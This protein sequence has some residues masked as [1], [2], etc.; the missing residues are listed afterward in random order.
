MSMK[1]PPRQ[2]N[3]AAS[4]PGGPSPLKNELFFYFYNLPKQSGVNTPQFQDAWNR[5]LTMDLTPKN[6]SLIMHRTAAAFKTIRHSPQGKSLRLAVDQG[7]ERW[8]RCALSQIGQFN[9]QNLTNSLWAFATLGVRPSSDFLH[10]WQA[11]AAMEMGAFTSQNLANSLWAFAT[12]GVQPSNDV[13]RQWQTRAAA[14]ID[15]FTPQSLVNSLWALAALETRHGHSDCHAAA[16]M[17]HKTI[18][19]DIQNAFPTNH[20]KQF[21]DASLWFDLPHSGAGPD[22]NDT[23]SGFEIRLTDIFARA[24]LPVRRDAGWIGA[25]KHQT[26]IAFVIEGQRFLIEMDGPSHF[27]TT[28]GSALAYNGHTTMQSALIRKC[29]PDATLIRIRQDEGRSLIESAD[30]NTL[31]AILMKAVEAG[32]GAYET[33]AE[34]NGGGIGL[35]NHLPDRRNAPASIRQPTPESA[36]V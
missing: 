27:I 17:L 30:R 25:L 32:P 35:K 26:D 24:G 28:P 2:Y 10:M 5:I 12:L 19:V 31:G 15:S 4:V 1:I 14:D 22:E 34:G 23:V 16:T 13:L 7:K 18:G 3:T 8:E 11:K 33:C 29:A 36:P 9:P 6:L 21:H 20:A